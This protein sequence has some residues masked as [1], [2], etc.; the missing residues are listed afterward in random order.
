MLI[1]GARC[2]YVLSCLRSFA[3]YLRATVKA[4]HHL[5]V[6][7]RNKPMP[8]PMQLSL[9]HASLGKLNPGF[10]ELIFLINVWRLDVFSRHSLLHLY[11]THCAAVLSDRT[12]LFNSSNDAGINECL[13]LNCPSCLPSADRSLLHKRCSGSW[14]RWARDRCLFGEEA[15]VV[16]CLLR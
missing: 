15:Q 1:N 4:T 14:A 10:V 5:C 3:P 12:G 13:D 11:S 8:V 7:K 16:G 6:S 2:C 9:T